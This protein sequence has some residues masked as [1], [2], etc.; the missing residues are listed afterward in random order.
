MIPL[1]DLAY[2][3]L[4][5]DFGR[6]KEAYWH[7]DYHGAAQLTTNSDVNCTGAGQTS[8]TSSDTPPAGAKPG[9]QRQSSINSALDASQSSQRE[10][11][12]R[13]AAF[14]AADH[15]ANADYFGSS[16]FDGIARDLPV[17]SILCACDSAQVLSE[18]IATLQERVGR[19]IGILGRDD[20][21]LN[22]VPAVIMLDDEDRKLLVRVADFVTNSEQRFEQLVLQEANKSYGCRVLLLISMIMSQNAVWPG[23][24]SPMSV[25]RPDH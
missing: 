15:L 5:V 3:R 20:V 19:Y 1:L 9:P 23:K 12:L 24:L 22:D 18:W 2:V 21:D 8:L 4:F 6:S 17:Q 16:F 7:R 10:S 13:K 14:Y 11:H 25:H